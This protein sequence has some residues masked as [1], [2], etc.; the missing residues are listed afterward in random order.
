MSVKREGNGKGKMERGRWKG[1]W[2]MVNG[3]S[4][5]VNGRWRTEREDSLRHLPFSIRHLYILSL[6]LCAFVLNLYQCSHH[7]GT[8]DTKV[9]AFELNIRHSAFGIRHWISLFALCVSV[10][11]VLNPGVMHQL[12]DLAFASLGV[13]CGFF[14]SFAF[15]FFQRL[16]GEVAR[17]PHCHLEARRQRKGDC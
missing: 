5:I 4:R 3:E 15:I 2:K 11:Q 1:K 13:L 9:D 14:V 10:V 12:L 16:T 6:S 7:Q 17:L 8:K